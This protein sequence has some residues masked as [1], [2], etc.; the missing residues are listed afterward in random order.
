MCVCLLAIGAHPAYDLVLALNRDEYYARPTAPAH[1]WHDRPDLVAGRDL[2]QGGTWL[3]VTRAG[4]VA[5]VTNFRD[6]AARVPDAL[7]RGLL[8]PRL[9]GSKAPPR[10]AL[11]A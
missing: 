4:R 9:L 10:E 2:E 7:S 5:L 11:E 6:P 8:V 1:F 3:G